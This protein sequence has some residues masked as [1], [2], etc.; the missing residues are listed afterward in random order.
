M[1]LAA[2]CVQ[3]P[4]GSTLE[5]NFA[6]AERLARQAAERGAEIVLLPEYFFSTPGDPKRRPDEAGEAVTAFLAAASKR[7]GVALAGTAV[8]AGPRGPENALFAYDRGALAGR[9][10]KIHPMPREVEN[11]IVGATDLAPF[12]LRGLLAGGIVCADI[13]YP[14]ASRVLSLKGAEI[15]LNPVMSP[16]NAVDPTKAAREAVFVARAWDGGAFVLKAGG[17]LPGRV[18]G[19]SLITAPWGT[20]AR[21]RDEFAEDVLVADLDLDALREFRKTHRGFQARAPGA[22]RSLLD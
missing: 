6:T 17:F 15:L 2:A 4:H 9:Q 22:Y 13:F 18:V 1:S 10:A 7:L 21:H 5:E 14:E 20:L 11:G 16:Y 12:P 3:M 8:V 19:R